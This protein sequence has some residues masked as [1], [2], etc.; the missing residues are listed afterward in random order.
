LLRIGFVAFRFEFRILPERRMLDPSLDERSMSK[1]NFWST[2]PNDR[3]T[4]RKPIFSC[5]GFK[6]CFSSS[7]RMMIGFSQFSRLLSLTG[8]FCISLA[9]QVKLTSIL[10][11]I[12][13]P[14]RMIILCIKTCMFTTH[15]K[16][17]FDYCELYFVKMCD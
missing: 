15:M 10:V 1:P 14:H 12:I 9:I 5:L 17:P 13:F 8:T 4:G 7:L 16:Y 6:T 3:L 2:C 11:I